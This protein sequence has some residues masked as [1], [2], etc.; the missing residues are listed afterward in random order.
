MLVQADWRVVIHFGV[1]GSLDS[2]QGRLAVWIN[3]AT[4]IIIAQNS[5]EE[6]ELLINFFK[7]GDPC[8]LLGQRLARS[9]LS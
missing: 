3:S 9:S 7:G 5:F 8:T 4:G 6:T 1:E 2:H